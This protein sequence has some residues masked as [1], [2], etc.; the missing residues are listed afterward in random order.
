MASLRILIVDDHE[1][2]RRGLRSLL[3]SRPEWEICGEAAD[4]QAAVEKVGSLHPDLVLMDVTM[5]VMTGTEAT[6]AIRSRQPETKV[7]IISQN[8]PEVTRRLAREAG[9]AAYVAKS[10]LSRDLLSTIDKITVELSP[11]ED[12][13]APLRQKKREKC[14]PWL[15]GGGD[16]GA[17]MRSKDWS[18]TA[19]GPIEKW[20]RSLQVSVGIC[21]SSR[22]D[23]IVWWGPDL[24]MLYNDS[25]RRTLGRKHP[26]ALGRPGREVY[27]EV[28]DVAGPMLEHVLKTGEATW[29]DN[30]ML[31]LERSGYP[32]ETYHTFSYTPIR[33]E[34]GRVVGVITPVAETTEQVISQRR[35]FT[36]R[37]LASRSV[38]AKNETEAW[39]FAAKALN[40]NPYDIPF[41]VLYKLNYEQLLAEAAAFTGIAPGH[42][43]LPDT[44]LWKDDS[45]I[46][47]LIREVIARGEMIECGELDRMGVQL[48]GGFWGGN[49]TNLVLVPVTQAGVESGMGV[50]V[51]GVNRHKRLD[52]DYRGFISLVANQIAK[53][54]ADA[55]IVDEER[56]RAESLA[57]LDR[58]KTTFFSNISHELRTPLTLILGPLEELLERT[59][60][61]HLIPTNPDEIELIHRNA[62]RLL[63]LVNTLLD[64]SRI[65]AGRMQAKYEPVRLGE[66]TAELASVF[67]SAVEKAGLEFDVRCEEPAATAFVD[68][69][70]W[71]KVVLNLLSNAL[72]FTHS[73]RITVRSGGSDGIAE[74]RVEDT[75]V[76]IPKSEMPHLFERFH[77]IEGTPGRTNEGTGIGLALVQELVKLHGGTIRAQSELGRGSQFIVSIPTGSNHLPQDRVVASEDAATPPSRGA[78]Q[79]LKEALG[80]LSPNRAEE[81]NVNDQ[82]VLAAPP[83]ILLVEDNSDMRLYLERLL[84]KEGFVVTSAPDGVAAI[85]RVNAKPPDLVLSDVMLPRLDGMTLLKR[86]RENSSLNDLPIILLSA[87]VGEEF[88]NDALQAG[89]TDYLVKPFHAH[90][91]VAR[92]KL[93][94]ELAGRKRESGEKSRP[95]L[96][97]APMGTWDFDLLTNQAFWSP[98][99]F[100]L[101]GYT[102]G[103]CTP[104]WNAW[105]E[106]VHPENREAIERQW[107]AAISERQEYHFDYQILLPDGNVRWVEANGR[108]Y[109]DDTG[110]PY[111][112]LGTLREISPQREVPSQDPGMHSKQEKQEQEERRALQERLT[113]VSSQA[114]LLDLVTD[115]AFI[116]DT[117]HKISYWNRA[118]E[119]LYGWSA[120]EAVG[121]DVTAL[122]QTEYPVPFAELLATLEENGRWEGELVH[123]TRHGMRV[124]VYSRWIH[125][126]G[127][128]G[129]FKGWL[130]IN[131][132]L[133]QQRQAEETARRLSGR[134]LQLQDEER[135]KMARELHDSVGQY[136]AM[137]KITIDRSGSRDGVDRSSRQALAECSKLVDQ[138]ISE[139]RTMSYLLH[140]PLLDENGLLSA[141]RWYVEG[142]A[143]RSGIEVHVNAPHEMPRLVKESETT[144]F[145]ILQESLTNV[146]RHSQSKSV[147]VDIFCD[148]HTVSLRVKDFGKGIPLERIRSFRDRG[149]GM[150][151]GLGGMRERVRELGGIL[152]IE[153][154]EPVG[155]VISVEI[156]LI[157]SRNEFSLSRLP[158]LSNEGK[159][160][161][162]AMV[163]QATKSIA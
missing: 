39:E 64:F 5:P 38:D 48:P 140:P 82:P 44:V 143:A 1:V 11:P 152:R 151:V 24:V 127:E 109:F 21:V 22:F 17:L 15:P 51:A 94:W 149:A 107:K 3:S 37:E 119:R 27:R 54:V 111:R 43:F 135:R 97:A 10:D 9:A 7:I 33:D 156:P 32:E 115:G 81:I 130:E 84:K 101:L 132:D 114:E 89:A 122:L 58:A 36:L 49:V 142:F 26:E 87:R 128:R 160:Q 68:R 146:H 29:S 93:H 147:S 96:G 138:C 73:G 131:A 59:R 88:R 159:G 126:R 78:S 144:L 74:L 8:E 60:G 34:Q 158:E 95:Q 71:E 80:W 150:G 20:P 106:R 52:E 139:T 45:R 124:V 103:G 40:S 50:L 117:S 102:A 161:V 162:S 136:L 53:S 42:P 13:A 83:E 28:W 163:A 98:G 145:R 23:L 104:S 148:T 63:K 55:R 14:P 12:L 86:L 19:L 79:F 72:K 125:K 120:P 112:D 153:P 77:R 57:E 85:E 25:Y 155:T 67:R 92:V 61:S 133:T 18:Q 35:L 105:M 66:L 134:I 157:E 118:A 75:G 30:L 46:A 91:L 65:E 70:M 154:G 6:R 110:R 123:T 108:F 90:E 47:Q 113:E 116:C 99:L 31:L 16:M 69:Q 62:S 129:E 121:Q 41:A 2:I 4:G 76:G 100:A 56:R 141:V 137:L